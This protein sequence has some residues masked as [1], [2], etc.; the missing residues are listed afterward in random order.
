LSLSFPH[1]AAMNAETR[2]SPDAMIIFLKHAAL[3]NQW[4][5]GYLA[6]AL[7]LTPSTA[8]QVAAEMALAGYIEPVR[9]KKDSWRNT[10][11]G[12]KLAGVRPPRLTRSKAEELLTDLEDRAAEFNMKDSANGVHLMEVIALGSILTDHDPIQDVDVGVRFEPTKQG[13]SHE[14]QLTAMKLL[15]GRS[16]A[17][18]LHLWNDSLAQM[19]A[20]AIWKS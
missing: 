9:G 19:S 15:K 2:I 11:A 13:H 18:K 6:K 4:T 17:L 12:N 7:G 1:A 14:H 3:E 5:V 20:R 10:A 8:K 16:S